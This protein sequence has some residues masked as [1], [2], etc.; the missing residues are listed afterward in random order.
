MLKW[1][2]A[3]SGVMILWILVLWI[4]PEKHRD[5]NDPN[6]KDEDFKWGST[7]GDPKPV[8]KT[9]FLGHSSIHQA[10]LKFTWDTSPIS[11]N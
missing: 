2:F 8:L 9:H 11:R 1:F 10:K 5:T 6:V 4:R 3:I 7:G